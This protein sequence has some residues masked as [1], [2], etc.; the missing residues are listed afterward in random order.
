MSRPSS[1]GDAKDDHERAYEYN[2]EIARWVAEVVMNWNH[3]TV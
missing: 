1:E 2:P 3:P